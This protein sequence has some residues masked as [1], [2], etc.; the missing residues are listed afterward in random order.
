MRQ[1]I[2]TYNQSRDLVTLGAWK[3]GANPQL[4]QAVALWPAVQRYLDQDLRERAGFAD[5]LDAL[6]T[7]FAEDDPRKEKSE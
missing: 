4:D 5:S 1:S 3:P 2:A 7:L 6:A